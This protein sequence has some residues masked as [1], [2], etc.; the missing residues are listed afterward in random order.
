MLATNHDEFGAKTPALRRDDPTVSIHYIKRHTGTERL[1]D[2][3][4]VSY[5][6]ALIADH[7]FPPPLPCPVKGQ[8]ATLAVRMDSRWRR[9]AVD[10][11]LDDRLPPATATALDDRAAA[12]AGDIMDARAAQLGLRV[13]DGGRA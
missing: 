6:E 9:D 7:A 11:W 12:E 13:M 10:L 3:A 2:R 5:V 4:L 8:G 1:K